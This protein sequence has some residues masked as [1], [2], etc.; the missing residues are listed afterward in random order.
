MGAIKGKRE[1]EKFK[2]GEKLSH[3]QAIMAQHYVCNGEEEGGID[4]LGKSC[5]LYQYMPYRKS[6]LPKVK[7]EATPKQLENLRKARIKRDSNKIKP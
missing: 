4:C 2:S 5:P 1:Y 3:K 6:R 7:R